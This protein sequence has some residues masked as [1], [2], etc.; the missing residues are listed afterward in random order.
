MKNTNTHTHTH[1]HTAAAASVP[2]RRCQTP[3]SQTPT[4]ASAV[5]AVWGSGGACIKSSRKA[6]ICFE[7]SS[8]KSAL[9]ALAAAASASL[10]HEAASWPAV[11]RSEL[12]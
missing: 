6:Q 10:S 8:A 11:T 3:A 2:L 7:L 5:I 1:T 4:D 12:S 9:E